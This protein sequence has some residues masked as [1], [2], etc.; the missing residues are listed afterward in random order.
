MFNPGILD[1]ILILSL[2]NYLRMLCILICSLYSFFSWSFSFS[3]S[4]FLIISSLIRVVENKGIKASK[5]PFFFIFYISVSLVICLPH[6]FILL[7]CV[8]MCIWVWPE[9]P[10]LLVHPSFSLRASFTS[11]ITPPFLI[12]PIRIQ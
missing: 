7:H 8:Y 3:H 11:S 2:W 4:F 12:P 10:C 5:E 9:Y 1:F 6:H